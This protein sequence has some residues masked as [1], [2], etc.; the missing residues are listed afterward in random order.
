MKKVQNWFMRLPVTAL[1]VVLI[2]IRAL[3]ATPAYAALAA[4]PSPSVQDEGSLAKL[5]CNIVQWF[6]EIV[7]VISV[8]MILYAAY[9]YMTAGDDTEKTSKARRTLTY[10]AVGIAVAIIAVGFPSLVS[11]IIPNGEGVSLSSICIP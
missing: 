7:L 6:F 8:I 9:N 3:A 10:A 11:S 2:G 5:L 4:L 1:S